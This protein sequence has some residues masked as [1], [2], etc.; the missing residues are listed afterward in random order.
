MKTKVIIFVSGGVVQQV[1]AT[2]DDI[3]VE[4][5]DWDNA[6]EDKECRKRCDAA[7]IEAGNMLD[8][9]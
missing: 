9:Y 1:S 8:V 6:V 4:V 2:T 5:A 7:E 3:D